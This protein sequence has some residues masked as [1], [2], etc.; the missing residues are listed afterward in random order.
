MK[1]VKKGT[2]FLASAILLAGICSLTGCNWSPMDPTEPNGTNSGESSGSSSGSSGVSQGNSGSGNSSGSGSGSGNGPSGSS[3]SGN[4]GNNSSLKNISSVQMSK[5]MIVGWNLGNTLDAPT[6]TAWSMPVT[7]KEMITAVAN[8]G[9]KTIRIP[10]SWSTHVSNDGNYTIDSAWMD[11]VQTIVDWALENNLYVI[12]N[13]HHDNYTDATINNQN[14]GYALSGDEAVRTKSKNYLSKVWTQIATR[15][16]SYDERLVFEALNEPRDIDGAWCGNEWW[17]NN[18]TVV[19]LVTEYEKVCLDA[20]RSVNGNENRF[21]MVPCFAATSD[22]DYILPLYKLPQ[23][24]AKDRLLLSVHAYIPYGFAM[25]DGSEHLDF[26][27]ED[28]RTLDR[29]FN[30][31]S[32]NYIKKGIGVV[33]GE[34]STSNK[35]NLAAREEWCSYY[36]KTLYEKGVAIVLWDNMVPDANPNDGEHHGYLNRNTCTWYF[37]SLIRRIMDAVGVKDYSIPANN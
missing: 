28:K 35:G 17:S 5:N 32:D 15:F 20:I 31:L 4:T 10:V 34:T 27:D 6:E 12:L 33:M 13:V 18:E 3:Y 22:I 14:G 9:F 30:Y 26:T 8:A 25:Y 7:T 11:R 24:S 23:D 2:A 21:V 16:A 37:P 36:F 29:V 1:M 19:N